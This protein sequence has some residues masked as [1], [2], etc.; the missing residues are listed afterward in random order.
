MAHNGKGFDFQFVMQA[1]LDRKQKPDVV[2]N[3]SKI[4]AIIWDSFRFV[5]SYNFV[6]KALSE[7]PKTFGLR[8]D[9]EQTLRSKGFFPHLFHTPENMT[10]V[11]AMPPKDTY[12]PPGM[13]PGKHEAF[14]AWYD[15]QV[16][17]GYV[18][19]M[20]DELVAYCSVDVTILREGMLAF[21]RKFQ[22]VNG[23]NP[24][25]HAITIASICN[26]VY[27]A[28][29]MPPMSIP[30]VKESGYFPQQNHS[31]KA[32]EWLVWISQ[33][34][35]GKLQ[36]VQNGGEYRPRD[37]GTGPV[38]GYH[39]PSRTCFEFYGCYWHGCSKC[40]RDDDENTCVKCSMDA[41]RN[42]TCAKENRLRA[43]GYQVVTMWECAWETEMRRERCESL[44]PTT[45]LRSPLSTPGCLLWR[46]HQL[47]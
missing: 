31:Y 40:Y 10:Y 14:T 18:F 43:H 32:V 29:H 5:D 16:Q 46:T 12:D 47:H 19:R 25:R 33:Q 1:L 28:Q 39:E 7:F 34:Y 42:K 45:R 21:C 36:H 30:Y 26:K 6:T 17:S 38:D 23:V 20:H 44:A 11:G 37:A 2:M 9:G 8:L 15:Q 3:G 13:R 35:P 22:Q 24:L 4:M 27:R 41:L